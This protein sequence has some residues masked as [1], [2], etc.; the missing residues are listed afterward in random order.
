MKKIVAVEPRPK[1]RVWIRFEDGIEGE[2]DLSQLVGKG[3]F[4][5]WADSS[6]FR[7]VFVDPETHIIAWPGGIDL[8]PD[9]LYEDVAGVPAT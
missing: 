6:E 5:G 9:T 2:V 7:K 1:Y 8:C 4:N 3:I